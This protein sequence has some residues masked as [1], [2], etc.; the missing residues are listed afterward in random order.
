MK[1]QA[2]GLTMNK[3][4]LGHGLRHDMR[5]GEE[6]TI[7]DHRC[8]KF[9]IMVIEIRIERALFQLSTG[10]ASMK[11]QHRAPAEQP[12]VRKDGNADTP[13]A[14]GQIQHLPQRDYLSSS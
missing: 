12:P 1:K 6:G 7:Q 9:D 4:E 3:P 5:P 13:L 10:R 2:A 8:V 14:R 11:S